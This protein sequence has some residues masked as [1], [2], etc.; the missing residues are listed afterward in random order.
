M[1]AAMRR[2]VASSWAPWALLAVTIV[3]HVLVTLAGSDAFAMVDLKVYLEGAQHLTDGTLYDFFSEP[4][5]LPFTYPTFSAIIGSGRA[6][7]P[8][9]SRVTPSGPTTEEPAPPVTVPSAASA[10]R[11]W[12][13]S[14]GISP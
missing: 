12:R 11:I 6:E 3:L 5:H 2:F 13:S 4:L 9:P 8:P 1:L 7:T 14:A 10:S